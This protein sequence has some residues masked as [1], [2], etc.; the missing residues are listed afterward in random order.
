M[1]LKK[2]MYQCG[3]NE[4]AVICNC[5]KTTVVASRYLDAFCYP[6]ERATTPCWKRREMYRLIL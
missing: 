4:T 6:C 1:C 5:G 3:H 2:W